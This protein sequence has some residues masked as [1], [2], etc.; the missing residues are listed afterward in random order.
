MW[1]RDEESERKPLKPP[2][3]RTAGGRPATVGSSVAVRGEL[4]GREDLT[5]DGTFEGE[6]KVTGCLVTI[7][8]EGSIRGNL[9]AEDQVIVRASGRMEGDIQAPRVALDEGCQFRGN[10][11]MEPARPAE[12]T[13][14]APTAVEAK[15]KAVEAP[16]TPAGQEPKEEAPSSGEEPSKTQ[17]ATPEGSPKSESGP[18]DQRG[19]NHR[20]RRR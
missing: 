5:I 15:D 18:S 17:E 9:I 19:R 13:A 7:A 1:N 2:E 12:E 20:N 11:D 4:V 14:A 6:I 10:I 3:N 8:V 16:T